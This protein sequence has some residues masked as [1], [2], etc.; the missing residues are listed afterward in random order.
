N[1]MKKVFV[2]T[3]SLFLLNATNADLLLFKSGLKKVSLLE[4]YTSEGCSSCPPAEKWLSGL[5]DS[6]Q[7]W[8][9]V[10]PV[11]FHVDYWDSQGWPDA[12]ASKDYTARQYLYV[13]KWNA[14]SAYTPGFVLN[15]KEWRGWYSQEYPEFES[16]EAPGEMRIELM[17]ENQFRIVFVPKK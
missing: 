7:L 16:S 13:Q 17:N 4:L 5:K 6:S 12:L 9:N 1:A 10:V 3:I 11:V 14:P 15:G 2:L 8:A